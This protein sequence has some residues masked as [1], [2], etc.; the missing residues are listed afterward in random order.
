VIITL[1]VVMVLAHPTMGA[2]FCLMFRWEMAFPPSLFPE[3]LVADLTFRD[4]LKGTSPVSFF[5][6]VRLIYIVHA[7][8]SEEFD[9]LLV[10]VPLTPFLVPTMDLS[11]PTQE[12]W[13]LST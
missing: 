9:A 7:C 1:S 3:T 4:L 11:R 10:P 8:V 12:S 13:M 5:C 2:R 6:K